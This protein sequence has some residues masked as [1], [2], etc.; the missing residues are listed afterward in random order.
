V[1]LNASRRPRCIERDSSAVRRETW[2]ERFRGEEHRLHIQYPAHLGGGNARGARNGNLTQAVGGEELGMNPRREGRIFACSFGLAAALSGCAGTHPAGEIDLDRLETQTPGLS[3]FR[4]GDVLVSNQPTEAG[5]AEL[6]TLGVR[7]VLNLRPGEEQRNFDEKA[8][9]EAL[10]LV[11]VHKPVNAQDL[12]DRKCSE[13]LAALKAAPPPVLV[14]DLSGSR[15]AGLWA[16]HVAEVQGL[17][18][19][20]ALEHAEEAGLRSGALR[21]FVEARLERQVRARDM[22]DAPTTGDETPV[23]RPPAEVP[24]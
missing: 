11:Y 13:V 3:C 6:Q 19:S 4:S 14:H 1:Y 2:E 23:P 10:G 5:F 12:D 8:I 20:C 21:D 9:V 18:P 17:A 16:L 15:A 22:V 7:T 24:E